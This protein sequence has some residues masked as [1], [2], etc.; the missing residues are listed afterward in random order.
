MYVV[1]THTHTVPYGR[2]AAE[3]HLIP[4]DVTRVTSMQGLSIYS[5]N[6]EFASVRARAV[7]K[8]TVGP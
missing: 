3:H 5:T 8:F 1:H 6:R 7:S 4:L 2:Q